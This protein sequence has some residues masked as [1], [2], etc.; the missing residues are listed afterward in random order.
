MGL[1][2]RSIGLPTRLGTSCGLC[3]ATGLGFANWVLAIVF[4]LMIAGGA[5]ALSEDANDQELTAYADAANLQNAG[6]FPAA[7]ESWK[8]FLDSHPSSPRAAQASHFLGVCYMQQASPDYVAAATAFQRAVEDRQSDLREESLINLGWCLFASAG[9]GQQRDAER[10]QGALDAFRLLVDEI[11]GSR[12][13]D[14]ALFYGGEAAYGLGDIAG[15]IA[16]YDRLLGREA[17][18]DSPLHRDALFARGIALEADQRLQEATAAYRQV[19]EHGGDGDLAIDAKLRLGDA[20]ILLQQYDQAIDWFAQ[21]IAEAPQHKPYALF[22]QAYAR[23][24]ANQPA[25]AAALYEQLTNEFPDSPHAAVALLA[26]AQTAYQAGDWDEAS[27][28]FE[29]VRQRGDRT[30]ATEAAHWL[31]MIAL[32]Q[33]R[34]QDAVQVAQQQLGA[35]SDGPFAVTLQMDVAEAMML[36]PGQTEAAMERFRQLASDQPNSPEAP[37]ALYN[38]TFAALQLGQYQQAGQW[39]EEFSSRF[40][41]HPLATD[42]RYLAAETQ[43]LA[44]NPQAAVESYRPL[45]DDPAVQQN[46]QY[47][48][49]VMRTATAL[50][51]AGSG[52]QAIE[53]L[54]QRREQFPPL[55]QADADY[56]LASLHLSA[57]D[58]AAAIA[59][60]QRCL[61]GEAGWPRADEAALQLGQTHLLAGDE[62]AAADQWEQLIQRF[63]D[64]IRSDQAR[65]RLAQLAAQADDHGTAVKRFDDLLASGRDPALKPAA[66][67]GRAWNLMRS[68]RPALAIESL[69]QLTEQFADHPLT[70]DAKLARG[71]CLRALDQPAEAT[72]QLES[73]LT[74]DPAGI[75]RGHA[76]HE[77]ALLD[78]QARR[79]DHAAG[80]LLQLITEVPDYPHLDRV[81][82]DLAWSLKESGNAD[83][84]QRRFQE[85]IQ[86]QPEGSLAAEAHYFVGQRLY[87]ESNWEQAIQQYRRA[88]QLADND[89]LRERASHRL[90]WALYRHGRYEEASAQFA[91]QIA[92][93]PSGRFL[94]DAQLMVG[95]GFFKLNRF[96]DAL[97]AFI[98]ARDRIRANNESAEKLPQQAERQVRELVLLHGGQS[99]SQLKRWPEALRWFAELQTRFP[100]SVYT[101]QANYET[102]YALQQT[103]KI[104]EAM[105]QY[106]AVAESQ[107]NE[108]G[109]RAHFMIGEI[110]FENDRFDDAIA[111]FQRVI[112]GYGGRQATAAIKPWQAQ[113]GYEAGRC[114][115]RLMQQADAAAARQR[116][117]AKAADFFR[118]VLQQHPQHDL[119][120]RSQ[121]RL[122]VLQ[123]LGFAPA[124]TAD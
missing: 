31:A 91:E 22:R 117:G 19:L 47:P 36:L 54:T 69:D 46:T 88:F 122:V 96:E 11:P 6:S 56:L 1:F 35:G 52:D 62:A 63:P 29:R 23:A 3:P 70:N 78:Q 61:D 92:E 118:Y 73:F 53:L 9:E 44:G 28:R 120:P 86:R 38:A 110:H 60:Y 18:A 75:N 83:E 21:V 106:Q 8:K 50:S 74:S 43:L 10:L 124:T 111:Q 17:T 80:R 109:A 104:D 103:G 40:A 58:Q 27:K 55:P 114:Y 76:L 100:Q 51:L 81:I 24:Q 41:E 20:C 2:D 95:E 7:I 87:S 108:I 64:S 14:R 59:A 65:Y 121:E 71:M 116:A 66:L 57:G 102:A 93:F 77:L 115:E 94:P 107:P 5:V 90:G 26:S 84:A 30:A 45:I 99:L 97:Q 82:Y 15:A 48:L 16:M 13:V 72:E 42:V 49:W 101:P 68:D 34:P 4:W 67:L 123:R 113:S 98:V 119:A 105:K 89:N 32:R 33:N 25:L 37:R 112:D 85:L 39:A 79:A 12:Y